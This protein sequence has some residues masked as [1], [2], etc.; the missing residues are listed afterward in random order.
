MGCIAV[1]L[2]VAV[3]GTIFIVNPLRDVSLARP[4]AV[5]VGP[6]TARNK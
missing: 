1:P 2:P 3:A 5:V 6:G 4:E